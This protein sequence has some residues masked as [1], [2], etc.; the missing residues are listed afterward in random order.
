MD[1]P[2]THLF[3]V[4]IFVNGLSGDYL[5]FKMPV[6][7]PG[8]Y[9]VRE[10]SKNI[11]NAE[12][13]SKK[14]ALHTVKISKNTWRVQLDSTSKIMF[15][16]QVYAFDK[17]VRTSSLDSEQAMV[18]GASVFMIPDGFENQALDITIEPFHEWQRI[19]TTLKS[20]KGSYDRFIAKNF[21][22]LID[23]PIQIGNHQ[24]ERF[25]VNDTLH[26]YAI[27]SNGNMDMPILLN[28]SEKIVKEV[29]SLFGNTSPYDHYVFFLHLTNGG[30]GGLE[31]CNS[32]SMIY[33]RHGFKDRKKYVRFLSLVSHEYFHTWN[34][35]RIR[36]VALGPFDY[37][38]EVYTTLL[39]VAEG[40]TSYYDNVFL[41]RAGVAT[42]K[43]YFEL[44]CEDVKGYNSI[45]GRDVMTIEESSFD[46]WIK[47]YRPNEN[48]IN[49]VIS[50]YL[51]GGLVMMSLDLTIRD[52]SDG[53]C[54]LD[55]VYGEFW[56]KFQSDGKGL[57]DAIFKSTCENKAGKN[58]DEIWEFLS[59][60]KPFDIAPYLEPF[61]VTISGDYSKET[62]KDAAWFGMNLKKDS[63]TIGS[64]RTD[65]SAYVAGIYA[66]DEL[67]AV[68][69]LRLNKNNATEIL[70]DCTVDSEVIIMLSREGLIKEI[71]VKPV[72]NPYDKYKIEK[73]EKPT[74]RQK[75]LYEGWLKQ[76]WHD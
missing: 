61:G 38:N 35:K 19:T 44:I 56:K 46:A 57:D 66:H 74:S 51:K 33:D 52:Q 75:Q 69:G 29:Q 45:P 60:T 13:S 63:T 37:F 24:I 73:V 42:A 1:D 23:S 2:H 55:D 58:L 22:D 8:S 54:S 21:D 49:S 27:T 43:E 25:T 6:W 59:T 67:I 14:G 26:E 50:Y 30:Y 36:P 9:L 47:L 71:K 15:E 65:G 39:W 20:Y 62:L 18:N 7:T 11:L 64:V 68:N 34:V 4:A 32:C 12:A 40:V 70:N 76:K 5:D 31:H 53:K 17:T 48:S 3:N 41:P 10:F 72:S 16:Y 28:D